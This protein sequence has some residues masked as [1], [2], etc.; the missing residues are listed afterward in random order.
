M[1]KLLLSLLIAAPCLV[2]AQQ[3]KLSAAQ[4]LKNEK[5]NLIND[6]PRIIQW[7][8]NTHYILA[9]PAANN[10]LDT[11]SVDVISGKEMP[12][13]LPAS[14]MVQIVKGDIFYTDATGVKRQLTA[15]KAEEKNPTFSPDKTKIAF[16]RDNDLYV[17]DIAT[18]KETRLSFDGSDVVYNG[19][20]SWVYYEEILGRASRYKAFWW[21]P[22]SKQIAYMRFD[23]TN[24]PVFPIYSSEGQH[25]FLENTRYPK[26]GDPNPE[27]KVGIVSI[28]TATTVWADFDAKKDQYFGTPFWSP[29]GKEL[30]QQ[31][32]NRGQDSLYI[33]AVNASNGTKRVAYFETQQTWVDWVDDIKFLSGNKGYVL[34][35]DKSGWN[36]VY[37]Y[38]MNGNPVK[39]ITTGEWTVKN[40]DLIDEKN[41]TIFFTARKENSARYDLYSIKMDG[42]KLARLTFGEFSH[43]ISLSPDGNYFLTNYSNVTTP[44]RIAL[45][46]VKKQS[47]TNLYDSKGAEL[48]QYQLAKTSLIRVTTPDGFALP[49][50]ITW[51]VNMD[52]TKKYPV[53]I[54]IYGGPNAGTVY[55]GWKGINQNQWWSQ[56]GLIQVAIDHR[57]SGHFGKAGQNFIF[58]NLSDYEIKD[59]TEVVKWL[60]AK[61][62]I[63]KEKICING[64]SYGGYVTC[65]ALT[66]AADYFTH[67]IAGGSVTDWKLYDSHYTE[68]FMDTPAENPEGYKVSAVWPYLKN[69]KGN[70]YIIHGTMDDNVHMQNSIQLISALQD[71]KKDFKF[72]L[73]PGGR[74]GWRN[75][76]EKWSHYNNERTQYFYQ[77]LLEK[78]VPAAILE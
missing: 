3:K 48:D 64:F 28:E 10:K 51:P 69:Y 60:T 36:H 50:L 34:T 49:V 7:Q 1:K 70:L 15:S 77:F 35:S 38:D 20:A 45:V 71:L 61:P 47:V 17:M 74:H 76:P 73:Y 66:R 44:N 40:I 33:Y 9:K 72:M 52:S 57:A 13:K 58:R 21:S 19:Y 30:W 11:V 53:L 6:L 29:D 78:P 46:N 54:N 41:K 22:D 5:T 16:T 31:W 56:E 43:T 65:M 24:V 23:D 25:G 4:M 32:M 55:D 39:Q 26:V 12:Y 63:N 42:T 14:E 2:L 75:L 37:H 62:Y 67:G 18:G 68:K 59:Y 27:V 8:D